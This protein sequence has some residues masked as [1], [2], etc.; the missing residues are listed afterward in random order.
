M[1]LSP[2]PR[3][4]LP[5]AL[6]RIPFEVSALEHDAMRPPPPSD[7]PYLRSLPL[8]LFPFLPIFPPLAGA[9][10]KLQ[11]GPRTAPGLAEDHQRGPKAPQET[12]QKAQ[13]IMSHQRARWGHNSRGPL[14][15]LLGSSR[16]PLQPLLGPV[17]GPGD[18]QKK[19]QE[20]PRGPQ[21]TSK[22]PQTSPPTVSYQDPL[23]RYCWGPSWG[24]QQHHA[25]GEEEETNAAKMMRTRSL[26]MSR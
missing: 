12:F 9:P 20:G 22:G 7:A 17:K 13:G 18:L 3:F 25:E 24:H 10:R 1:G 14:G 21:R 26:T 4:H 8:V 6:P 23:V 16:G 15:A 11:E 5:P 19:P 2:Q